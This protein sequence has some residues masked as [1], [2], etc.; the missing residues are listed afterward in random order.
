MGSMTVGM[1]VA[2]LVAVLVGHLVELMFRPVKGVS[3]HL[4]LGN[5]QH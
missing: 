1:L 3:A 2:V 4:V 5:E